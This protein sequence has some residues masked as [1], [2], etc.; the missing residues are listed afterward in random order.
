MRVNIT[1]PSNMFMYLHSIKDSNITIETYHNYL[2]NE[3]TD[4]QK[5]IYGDHLIAFINMVYFIT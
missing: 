4:T 5:I 3:P 1:L 2:T